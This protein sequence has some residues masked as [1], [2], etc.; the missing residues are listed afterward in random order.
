[1]IQYMIEMDL[2]IVMSEKFMSLIPKQRDRINKLLARGKVKSYTLSLD[3]SKL[4]IIAVAENET[5]LVEMLDTLPLAS[6]MIPE[7]TELMFH[8]SQEQVLQFS[9]N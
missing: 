7:I 1:M 5:K 8:N 9:L 2:P 3:R 4:W 6:Y